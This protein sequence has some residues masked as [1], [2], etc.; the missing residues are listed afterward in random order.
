MFFPQIRIKYFKH[1]QR[2]VIQSQRTMQQKKERKMGR[3]KERER[4]KK[5]QT[6]G[7]LIAH[8]MR[9]GCELLPVAVIYVFF[10]VFS[11][12]SSRHRFSPSPARSICLLM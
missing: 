10:P 11:A 6:R 1:L 7:L 3:E 5:K 9:D 4:E 12:A 8:N 2:L